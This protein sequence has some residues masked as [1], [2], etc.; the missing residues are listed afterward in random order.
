MNNLNERLNKLGEGIVTDY[1]LFKIIKQFF[2]I[3]KMSLYQFGTLK[4]IIIKFIKNKR[5]Q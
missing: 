5:I 3:P 2:K 4:N 1:V